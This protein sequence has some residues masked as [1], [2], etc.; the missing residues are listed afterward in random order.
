MFFAYGTSI[1]WF[2]DL[3]VLTIVSVTIAASGYFISVNSYYALTHNGTYYGIELGKMK[4]VWI[5]AWPYGKWGPLPAVWH[6]MYM[7]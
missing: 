5:E 1:N 7:G 2:K 4:R 3:D 6:P